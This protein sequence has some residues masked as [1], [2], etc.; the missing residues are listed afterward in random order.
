MTQPI[1]S[2]YLTYDGLTDPLGQSQILPYLVG[3]SKQGIR[4]YVVSFE[5]KERFQKLKQ[6][7]QTIC[8][9]NNISW[10]PLAYTK[11]P[12]VLST[13]WDIWKMNRTIRKLI[14]REDITI[15]HCRSY[16]T[17]LIG[18]RYKKKKNVRFI[19]DMRGFWADE[20]VDGHIWNIKNPVFALI[21]RYFKRKEKEFL[22]QSDAIVSLTEAAKKEITIQICPSISPDKISV[23]PCSADYSKFKKISEEEVNQVKRELTISSD[24]IVL[25][26]LGSLGTW[27]MLDEM[28]HFFSLFRQK[29]PNSI[30]LFITNDDITSVISKSKTH[31]IP[32]EAIKKVSSPHQEVYRYLSVCNL[33][34][35]FIKPTYSKMAS[36]A[37]KF[38]EIMALQIPIV[39]NAIGDLKEHIQLTDNTY[40][41]ERFDEESYKKA[42]AKIDVHQKSIAKE[43]LLHWYDLTRAL[44]EYKK[45]YTQLVQA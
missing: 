32:V 31:G 35:F 40:C 44:L 24:S 27:Y 34:V 6:P 8:K 25:G 42:L 30:F 7:I 4:F 2:I 21:Y 39:C 37:T 18:L 5:K 36:S 13:L 15:L 28:L 3:L 23:I 9:N 45:I 1:T 11:K 16:I 10:I 20:R 43:Y 17:S 14:T 41:I 22:M 38:A 29:Y 26:Y 12:P 19:F 33:S